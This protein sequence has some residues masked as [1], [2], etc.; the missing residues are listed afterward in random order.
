MVEPVAHQHGINLQVILDEA[1]ARK[2]KEK[3]LL[4]ERLP[5]IRGA[6]VHLS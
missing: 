3:R 4:T 6:F 1:S 5:G 2:E